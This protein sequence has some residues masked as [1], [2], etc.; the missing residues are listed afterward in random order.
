MAPWEVILDEKDV[1]S[2]LVKKIN[3]HLQTSKR[4]ESAVPAL[5]CVS[6]SFTTYRVCVNILLFTNRFNIFLIILSL[7]Y[8]KL[9]FHGKSVSRS[10]VT[11]CYKSRLYLI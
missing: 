1:P 2:L 8:L 9:S 11:L 7:L 4:R 6:K 10:T 5:T 3:T